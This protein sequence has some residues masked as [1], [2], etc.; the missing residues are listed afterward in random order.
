MI[1]QNEYD[2]DENLKSS[3]FINEI[4]DE[5][6]KIR[7]YEE[8]GYFENERMI[9]LISDNKFHFR[10]TETNQK[11]YIEYTLKDN[12]DKYEYTEEEIQSI[13]LC[14]DKAEEYGFYV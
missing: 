6:N 13:L 8:C 11:F 12:F 14:I 2:K 5:L 1:P 10:D 3:G 7:E 4:E 9:L